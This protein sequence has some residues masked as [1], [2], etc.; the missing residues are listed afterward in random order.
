MWTINFPDARVRLIH[1]VR[2][3][4]IESLGDPLIAAETRPDV[5]HQKKKCCET[6]REY[7]CACVS[8]TL[9]K[10]FIF[11][12]DK[13]ALDLAHKG[14]SCVCE[15]AAYAAQIREM[16]ARLVFGVVL[17]A[18]RAQLAL[19]HRKRKIILNCLCQEGRAK[20]KATHA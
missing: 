5:R 16:A 14:Q 13:R 15:L 17:A 1:L 10:G 6:A 19:K 7:S 9:S 20:E 8:D 4:R 3:S 11:G 12:E 2:L 18:P